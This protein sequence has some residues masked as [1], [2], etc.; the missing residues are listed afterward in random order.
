MP[1]PRVSPELPKTTSKQKQILLDLY[2]FRFLTTY[3]IQKLLNH[4]NPKRI[5][6]W[7]KDLLDKKCVNRFYSRKNFDQAT[8]PAIYHLAAKARSYLKK[9]KE[10]NSEVL[11]YIYKEHRKEQP[12]IKHCLSIADVYLFLQSQR[13]PKEEIKFFTKFELGEY[14]HFPQ[15][16]PDAF[17]A[18]N[19]EDYTRRYFLDLFDDY[20]PPFA[21]RKRVRTYLEYAEY[22]EWDEKTNYAPLPKILFI[23]SNERAKKHIDHYAKSLFEKTYSDKI[24]LFLTTLPQIQHHL[25][26]ETIWQKVD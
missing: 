14:E 4:K 13:D 1:N 26:S 22:S 11:E 21:L 12:F 3:Q 25:G 6:S 9:E 20:T 18:V 19:G 15:P 17:V 2:K 16:L 10:L 7:L 24:S 8:K 5:Q 23:F